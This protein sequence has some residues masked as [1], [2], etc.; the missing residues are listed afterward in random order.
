MVYWCL[1]PTNGDDATGASHATQSVAETTPYKTL[2]AIES[3]SPAAGDFILF[4]GGDFQTTSHILA[5]GV[6]GSIGSPITFGSYGSGRGGINGNSASHILSTGSNVYLT[7]DDFEIKGGDDT[8]GIDGLY[9]TGATDATPVNVIFKNG[10]IH[11]ISEGTE[12][13]GTGQGMDI[14][15]ANAEVVDTLITNV[16]DDGIYIEGDDIEIHHCEIY[17]VDL[18]H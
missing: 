14:R 16:P 6:D 1:S 18:L 10:H 13:A 9:I 11:H 8:T 15:A 17:L 3:A 12:V 2:S 5:A 4:K 7:F